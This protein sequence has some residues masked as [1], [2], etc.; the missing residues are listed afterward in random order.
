MAASPR[1]SARGPGGLRLIAT[2]VLLGGW[3][4]MALSGLLFR[5]VVPTLQAIALG[6]AGVLGAAAFYQ[7]L[8]VTAGELAVAVVIGG[9]AGLVV[10]LVLG[11]SRFLSVA[12]E[13]WLNYLGPTP[14]II[15]F[16]VMILLF[17]VGSGS[18]M[19]MGA[20]SCF[21]PVAISVAAGVRGVNPI[22]L[23]V[24]PSFRA[25]RWAMLTK[26]YLPAM[27][28]PLVNGCRLGFGVALIG[29]LLAKT[30]LSNQGIGFMVM[31]A[32]QRFDMPRMYGLLLVT[33]AFAALMN[34]ATDRLAARLSG[35]ITR[36][37]KSGRYP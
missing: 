11:G 35:T 34:G 6:L 31:Q 3:Q 28:A 27:L 17:G 26:I 33:V 32:Y 30:K 2:I 18:K 9:G 20:V 10:G 19:A 14:K 21:F 25:G 23:R 22:L 4:A 24:G 13:R 1:M 37:K 15:L 36:N 29:V 5:D 8:V 16:P 12:L 7:N